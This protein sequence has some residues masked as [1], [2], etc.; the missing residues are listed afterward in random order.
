MP[1]QAT[2]VTFSF[3]PPNIFLSGC[4][5][6]IN[7]GR[8]LSY[9]H[10]IRLGPPI[11]FLF[12]ASSLHPGI[13]P[14]H[15][16]S[17]SLSLASEPIPA[18][19]VHRIRSG[20]FVEMRDLLG[21]NIALNQHFEGVSSYFPAQV[22]PASSRPRLREATSLPSWIYCFFNIPGRGHALRSSLSMTG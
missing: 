13:S 6:N 11:S 7:H 22:L 8:S 15:P 21:D 17:L 5:F 1:S 19:L 4:A 9:I 2:Q 10:T 12:V 3:P 14:S 18:R 20:Q 16:G